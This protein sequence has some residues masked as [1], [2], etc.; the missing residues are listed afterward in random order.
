MN[1]RQPW[2]DR[3]EWTDSIADWAEHNALTA[4]HKAIL[5]ADV[6]KADR[7]EGAWVEMQGRPA[8]PARRCSPEM[9]VWVPDDDAPSEPLTGFEAALL[10]LIYAAS[11]SFVAWLIA[12]IAIAWGN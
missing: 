2:V 10:T 1:I 5:N 8:W 11:V 12:T 3:Y 9:A 4:E 6:S 7:N